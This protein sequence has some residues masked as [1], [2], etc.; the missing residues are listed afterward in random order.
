MSDTECSQAKVEE[1]F[2]EQWANA[3]AV[4]SYNM[5][6]QLGSRAD[7]VYVAHRKLF[8]HKNVRVMSVSVFFVSVKFDLSGRHP[9]YSHMLCLGAGHVQSLQSK[10]GS[11][12]L[13]AAA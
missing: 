4:L 11:V 10:H 3:A 6:G 1:L 12:C 7:V 2:G 9:C 8:E 5:Q 13:S